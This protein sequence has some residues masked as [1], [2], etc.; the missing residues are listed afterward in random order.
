MG[1]HPCIQTSESQ[2][3]LSAMPTP[4][5]GLVHRKPRLTTKP[6][7]LVFRPAAHATNLHMRLTPSPTRRGA[8]LTHLNLSELDAWRMMRNVD[9]HPHRRHHHNQT[10]PNGTIN[11]DNNTHPLRAPLH[12]RRRHPWALCVAPTHPERLPHLCADHLLSLHHMYP[13]RPCTVAAT[14]TIASTNESANVAPPCTPST[15]P[16]NP[17]LTPRMH[18]HMRRRTSIALRTVKLGAQPRW[19]GP[20]WSL[21]QARFW[22]TCMPR[23]PG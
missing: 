19:D 20:L 5:A 17:L 7:L 2:N 15:L 22:Q 21:A 18:T 11:D 16:R 8:L 1:I 9:A 13:H 12:H 6:A 14:K 3:T 10:V 4:K 23:A